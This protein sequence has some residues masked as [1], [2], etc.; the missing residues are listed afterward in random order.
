MKLEIE[1]DIVSKIFRSHTVFVSKTY[2][3]D[4]VEDADDSDLE[5]RMK[6]KCFICAWKTSWHALTRFTMY[7]ATKCGM[8]SG[9]W[10]EIKCKGIEIS[11]GQLS[12]YTRGKVMNIWCA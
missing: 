11:L 12:L 3:S 10:Y 8:K 6:N 7:N 9:R 2:R 1:L 5:K 4:K